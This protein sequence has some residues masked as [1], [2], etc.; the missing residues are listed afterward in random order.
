MQARHLLHRDVLG[1]HAPN[2][3]HHPDSSLHHRRNLHRPPRRD[4]VQQRLEVA[5]E[6]QL[7][8]AQDAEDERIGEARAHQGRETLEDALQVSVDECAPDD[9]RVL[10]PASEDA[11]PY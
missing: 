4:P 10:A 11:V 7:D 6:H 2:E 9:A 8:R 1:L 5:A 3:R